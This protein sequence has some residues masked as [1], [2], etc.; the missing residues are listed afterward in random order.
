MISYINYEDNLFERAILTSIHCKPD[1]ETLHKL[2][3]EIKTN[4][5]AVYSNIRGGAHVRIGLV[6]ANAQYVLVLNT[7]FVYW[8]H[9]G[10][11][12]IA[13]GTTSHKN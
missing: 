13:D 9:S 12:S 10:L 7:P 8:T 2:L 5:K 4:V 3:N 11:I 1:F 6:L